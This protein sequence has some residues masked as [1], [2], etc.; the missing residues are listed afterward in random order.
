MSFFSMN[1]VPRP[2]RWRPLVEA[3]EDRLAP[4]VFNPQP[5]PDST[6]GNT[7]RAAVIAADGNGQDNTIDLQAGLY[8]LT[9]KN[10]NDQHENASLTG[11][12]N[13][14]AAGHTLVIQGAGPD[15]TVID[16][17]SID[18]AFQ[19]STGVTVVFRNLSIINGVAQDDGSLNAK[20]GTTDALGGAILN[21][22]GNVS[23][24]HVR[25]ENDGAVGG[26]AA[27]GAPGSDGG[28]GHNAAGG[29]VWTAGGALTV[30]DCIFYSNDAESGAGGNGG[31]GLTIGGNGGSA[32]TAQGGALYVGGGAVSVSDST[33][34]QNTATDRGGGAGGDALFIGGNGGP[35]GSDQGG[36]VFMGSGQVLISRSTLLQNNTS[37]A[38]ALAPGGGGAA[39]GSGGAGSPAQGGALYAVG[40]TLTLSNCTVAQNIAE[41]G[42]GSKGGN[43]AVGPGGNGGN[44]GASQG[45]AILVAAGATLNLHNTTFADNRVGPSS[46]GS[47]GSGGTA[48]MAGNRG[49]FDGSGVRNDGGTVNAASTLFAFSSASFAGG[50]S[51]Y[52]PVFSGNF[53]T[54]SHNLVD[55]GTGAT[56]IANGVDGNL[57]GTAAN[58]IDARLRRLDNYGGPTLTYALSPDSPAID[59][60][61]NPDGLSTDQR[62]FGPR[63][64]NGA[65]DIGAFEFGAMPPAPPLPPNAV[66]FHPVSVHLVRL[67]H[68]RIRLDVFDGLTG[69]FKGSLFPFARKAKMQVLTADVNGDGYQD[70]I[71]MAVVNSALQV[72]IFSGLSLA[73][74]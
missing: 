7:L 40:G 43:G 63:D 57:V 3:L 23:L 62:G 46:G 74:L 8:K 1:R 27:A 45:G 54:A 19:V 14:T 59:H 38:F 35:G 71:A 73:P 48:G 50:L 17:N 18:R 28:V 36:A 58:H 33:F 4:A 67:K 42:D 52:V 30:L 6:T 41:G 51:L 68:G 44:G 20:A 56:G 65:A 49:I 26:D 11:D 34:A 53:T 60:G 12:L 22:G 55:D 47:G 24:D 69:A 5:L 70:V 21:Q 72:H 25:L 2:R 15:V 61:S 64:V 66:L 29:A 10:A 37:G 32:G 13:L 9:I 39:G 16:A 31:A